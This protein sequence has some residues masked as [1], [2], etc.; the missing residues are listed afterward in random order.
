MK[1][2]K[3]TENMIY[4]F[5]LPKRQEKISASSSLTDLI[6][7]VGAHVVDLDE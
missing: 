3:P 5:T 4:D 7:G 6:E 1:V 2:P